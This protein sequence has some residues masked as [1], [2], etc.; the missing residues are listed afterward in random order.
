MR[1]NG[2]FARHSSECDDYAHILFRLFYQV[3]T[4]PLSFEDVG[5]VLKG[6]C[7]ANIDMWH[8][9]LPDGW[10]SADGED[11]ID[12]ND[13]KG[14]T[15]L[16]VLYKEDGTAYICGLRFYQARFRFEDNPTGG[17]IAY[18]TAVR[19]TD[20]AVVFATRIVLPPQPYSDLMISLAHEKL[21]K[22]INDW[23]DQNT[24]GWKSLLYGW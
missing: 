17:I 4:Y 16:Q 11:S 14:N 22:R 12:F 20:E 24:P 1:S 8:M 13:A 19:R 5:I 10:R 7:P 6:G 21:L 3:S 18:G 9:Q 23:L 15:R 2:A